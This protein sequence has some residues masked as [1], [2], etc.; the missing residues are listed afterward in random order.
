MLRA[1]VL[2]TVISAAA[3]TSSS[4]SLRSQVTFVNTLDTSGRCFRKHKYEHLVAKAGAL[5]KTCDFCMDTFLFYAGQAVTAETSFDHFSNVLEKT[6]AK[7][8]LCV[9]GVLQNDNEKCWLD[10]TEGDSSPWTAAIGGTP[11]SDEDETRSP[12]ESEAAMKAA[13]NSESSESLIHAACK[14]ARCCG[15]TDEQR[16]KSDEEAAALAAKRQEEDNAHYQAM[17]AEEKKVKAQ[18]RANG[19]IP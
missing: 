3:A 16:A 5:K 19:N 7:Q 4:H 1:L 13:V 10:H 15:P 6:A 14:Y 9:P 18:L 8:L 2:L 11:P 12:F 17:N